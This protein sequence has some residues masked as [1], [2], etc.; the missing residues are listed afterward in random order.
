MRS[1]H[2]VPHISAEASGPSYSVPALCAA[3]SQRGDD[4][5]LASLGGDRDRKEVRFKHYLFPQTAF[6][7]TLA[8]SRRMASELPV[9][10]RGMDVV[11]NNNLW[12]MPPI[13]AA[14]AARAAGV[15]LVVSPRGTLNPHALSH[16]KWK[17]RLFW[18]LLQKRSISGA[19]AFHATSEAEYQDIRTFGFRAPVAVVPNG[20]DVPEFWPRASRS[21]G[22]SPRRLLYLGRI[23][24]IKGLDTL[25]SAWSRV[26]GTFPDWELKLVGPDED[27]Y[28]STLQALVQRLA[29]PRIS[30]AG[31]VSSDEKWDEYAAA[32]LYVLP[33]LSENFAISVAEALAGGCPA[34]VTRGAPWSGLASE[35]A[36][37][38]V[39]TSAEGLEGALRDA[40]VRPREELAE[41]G[42]NGRNW[43]VREFGWSGIAQKMHQTYG[44]LRTGGAAPEWVR[45]S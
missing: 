38:W 20:V 14:R 12:G 24:P 7:S 41:M 26:A 11:H 17:K 1:L 22:G 45:L 31:P 42:S 27:S 29:T 4:V 35:R 21:R 36:G 19:A 40:M 8:V 23:H 25:I 6:G 44:W 18:S 39:D 16:S 15:P 13:Y 34:I 33:S 37:W 9:I 5:A 10:A 32:D 43:M 28:Q 30:F 2:V 3:L